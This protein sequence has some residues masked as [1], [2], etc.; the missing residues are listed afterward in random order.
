MSAYQLRLLYKNAR[1]TLKRVQKVHPRYT[2]RQLQ[3]RRQESLDILEQFQLI[4]AK[5]WRCFYLDEAV[6]SA[7][8][9]KKTAWSNLGQNILS[10][11]V[12][13]PPCKAAIGI[14]SNLGLHL[15][16]IFDKS[17]VQDN[18]HAFLRAFRESLGHRQRVAVFHDGLSMH[19]T[20]ASRELYDALNIESVLIIAYN[21]EQ[22]PQEHIWLRSKQSYRKQL[23]QLLTKVNFKSIDFHALVTDVLAKAE[24]PRTWNHFI[25]RKM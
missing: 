24:V 15:Y 10:Q 3:K 22:N 1:I 18:Y 14:C 13:M 20:K 19:K 6:F 2:N 12:Y 16:Q 23:L 21:S 4:E 25:K 17:V 9:F 7:K 5:K 11:F 8:D